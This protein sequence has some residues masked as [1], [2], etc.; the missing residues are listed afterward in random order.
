MTPKELDQLKKFRDDLENELAANPVSGQQQIDAFREIDDLTALIK[1]AEARLAQKAEISPLP[2]TELQQTR[3]GV[4]TA[5]DD[6]ADAALDE[7]A[8][9]AKMNALADEVGASRRATQAEPLTPEVEARL[10]E[11]DDLI[12]KIE[13]SM[14]QLREVTYDGQVF[15]PRFRG[16]VKPLVAP[17]SMRGVRNKNSDS[18][19]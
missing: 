7:A 11:L 6:L 4:A 8:V 12:E 16:R 13:A 10:Q 15:A 5:L 18:T 19:S 1:T 17:R 9:D 14:P 2:L 3:Q